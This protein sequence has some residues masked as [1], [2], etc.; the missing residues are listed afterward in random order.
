VTDR[1]PPQSIHRTEP[2]GERQAA[3]AAHAS[4]LAL[5]RSLARAA[6]RDLFAPQQPAG[7]VSGSD[8]AEA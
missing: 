1:A 8:D 5:V 7:R 3:D 4:A 2:P 6:A